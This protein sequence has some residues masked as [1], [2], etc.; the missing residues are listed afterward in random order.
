M[1]LTSWIILSIIAV[2]V[3]LIIYYLRGGKSPSP[4]ASGAS[5]AS[6]APEVTGA[7]GCSGCPSRHRCPYN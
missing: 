5:G 7:K 1:N 2:A 3:A 6:R 4:G